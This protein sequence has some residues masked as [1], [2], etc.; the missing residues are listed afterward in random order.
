MASTGLWADNP[1][2]PPSGFVVADGVYYNL[3][4]NEYVSV[5]RSQSDYGYA[6]DIVI[7]HEFD[8]EDPIYGTYHFVVK[9]IESGVFRNCADLTSVEMQATT[10]PDLAESAFD[11]CTSLKHIYVPYEAILT[12]QTAENWSNYADLITSKNY[13]LDKTKT[14]AK[15]RIDVRLDGI[16]NEGVN[17]LVV[18]IKGKIDGASTL[19]EVLKLEQIASNYIACYHGGYDDHQNALPSDPEGTAGTA[20]IIIKEEKELKLINPDKVKYVKQ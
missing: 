14:D 1:P 20:V 18:E 2:E 10:P 4:S 5:A 12:Y 7:P 3:L 19:E 17:S 11:G 15:G 16:D 8:F 13:D 9:K 6:G